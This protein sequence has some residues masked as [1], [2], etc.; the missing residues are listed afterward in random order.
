MGQSFTALTYSKSLGVCFS[1]CKCNSFVFRMVMLQL[2]SAKHQNPFPASG[3]CHFTLK[4]QQTLFSPV[5]LTW[6]V[7]A[8]AREAG[9]P[10]QCSR[11]YLWV[12]KQSVAGTARSLTSAQAEGRTV[13]RRAIQLKKEGQDFSG[14]RI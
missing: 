3:S 2:T 12:Q 5:L 14:K 7:Q 10:A 13:C 6:Q 8:S 4:E 1:L 9:Q 11:H